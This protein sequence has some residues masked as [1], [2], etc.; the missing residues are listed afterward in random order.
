M[1]NFKKVM[2][3]IFWHWE[4]YFEKRPKNTKRLLLLYS[5]A[6]YISVSRIPCQIYVLLC[7]HLRCLPSLQL[8]LSVPPSIF[9]SKELTHFIAS[10][11]GPLTLR[12]SHFTITQEVWVRREICLFFGLNW[13]KPELKWTVP[14]WPVP[15]R[16][17]L[18]KKVSKNCSS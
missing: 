16:Q 18:M 8:H 6:I 14:F 10:P 9:E 2:L 17:E 15:Q 3:F 5:S 12:V 4:G 11:R 7:R 1:D 13:K